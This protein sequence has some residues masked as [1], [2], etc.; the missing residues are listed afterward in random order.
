MDTLVW[1]LIAIA[2]L[3]VFVFAVPPVGIPIILA[4]IVGSVVGG[5]LILLRRRS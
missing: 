2:G 5:A 1:S 3:T 4:V